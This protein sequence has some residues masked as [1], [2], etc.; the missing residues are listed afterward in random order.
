VDRGR[1]LAFVVYGSLVPLD[2]HP[3]PLDSA[4]RDFLETRY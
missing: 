3:R 2:Y 1:L 4:W